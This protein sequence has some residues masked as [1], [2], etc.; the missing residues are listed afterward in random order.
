MY[1]LSITTSSVTF[2]L[3]H[4]MKDRYTAK[5]AVQKRGCEYFFSFSLWHPWKSGL[6]GSVLLDQTPENPEERAGI[7]RRADI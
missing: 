1:R 6:K 5:R 3:N 7:Q 2:F 4:S